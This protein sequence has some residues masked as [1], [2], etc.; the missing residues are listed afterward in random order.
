MARITFSAVFIMAR[1]EGV[2]YDTLINEILALAW[3]RVHQH[4]FAYAFA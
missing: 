3:D 1:A 4:A 2:S